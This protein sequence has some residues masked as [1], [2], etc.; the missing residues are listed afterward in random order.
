MLGDY[1]QD[2]ERYHKH[3]QGII[4]R[5]TYKQ[6]AE[7]Q[8]RSTELYPQTGAVWKEGKSRWEWP[9][10]AKLTF[11][12]L[13][14]DRDAE[15]YQ[16]HAYA[17]LGFEELGN[18]PSPDPYKKLLACNRW[19]E[20]DIPTK[21]VRASGNPGGVGQGWIREY[22][23]DHAP[24][25]FQPRI[26]EKTKHD[27]MF[28]P[29]KVSD[30]KILMERDPGY[31]DTIKGSGN[32]ALVKAW[33]DGDWNAI[34]GGYF[35]EFGE[36]HVIQPF[37]IPEHW[38]RFRA[39]DWGSA[40]PF[41][42]LWMTVSDGSI[43]QFPPNSIIVYREWYGGTGNVGLKMRSQDVGKG[44]LAREAK[45]E[46]I[47]YTVADPAM[48][49]S[50][51]GPS[52][53]ENLH[54]EGISAYRGD[55]SRII[56]WGQIRDRLA[57]YDGRPMLYVVGAACANLV[58]TLPALQHDTVKPE[59][60]DCFIAG[61][62]VSTLTGERNI[63]DIKQGE[64]ILTPIGYR[65]AIRANI[66]G[67]GRTMNVLLSNGVSLKGT[68]NHKIFV[69]G[70]GLVELRNLTVGDTLMVRNIRLWL[71]KSNTTESCIV[72]GRIATTTNQMERIY[73]RGISPCIGKF[74]SIISALSQ[75]VSTFTTKIT[76]S[77]ITAPTISKH[78][79]PRI[80][81]GGTILGMITQK[82]GER[83]SREKKFLGTMPAKCVN[84]HLKGG[85]RAQIVESLL[86]RNTRPKNIAQSNARRNVLSPD[87]KPSVLSAIKKSILGLVK[88]N[89]LKPVHILAVGSL[90]EEPRAVYNLTVHEAHLYYANGVLVTNT[91]GDDHSA[92]ALRYGC[93]S[94]PYTSPQ[95]AAAE[96]KLVQNITY[97][98]LLP[99]R[100]PAAQNNYGR[101]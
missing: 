69:E 56:G 95:K 38:T 98:D 40:K 68:P 30:N 25:G 48:F 31:I 100:R 94:R 87:L 7:L 37:T 75:R 83:A 77:T 58:R 17:W 27:V 63:E 47:A 11:A 81:C 82:P 84:V 24:L 3:W 41:S 34:V 88:L 36:R 21:R 89:R 59:D 62:K 71:N 52:T 13:D 55:N 23:I 92:D 32:D 44:I 61:T 33:L 9:N 73:L 46:K 101:I 53:A 19:A 20:C 29:A 28:I 26:D 85:L 22:F 1:L 15:N 4:F 39:M 6:L 45:N 60:V 86:Q 91:E 5:R 80:T 64:F 79:P 10:G 96:T 70:K 50:D 43:P 90:E 97:D 66:S 49:N 72:E 65:E 12:F 18:F 99:L 35:T 42:V 8:R 57:G 76:I 67:V 78:F 93:M 16:G 2:V 74:T 51:D 14:R 54:G